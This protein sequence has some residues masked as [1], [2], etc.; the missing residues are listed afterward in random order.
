MRVA[1][2]LALNI[3]F[4]IEMLLRIVSM[5]GI[6]SY[7]HHPW[8]AFDCVMV[9]AGY[10][11]FIPMDGSAGSGLEGLKAL[12]ALRA[13]R[14]LRTIT[15]WSRLGE[16][17]QSVF[18]ARAKI[19]SGRDSEV[20]VA[21]GHT[22]PLPYLTLEGPHQLSHSLTGSLPHGVSGQLGCAAH[23]SQATLNA[24]T[25]MHCVLGS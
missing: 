23:T 1:A 17:F 24:P 20:V 16:K 21:P 13:M 9:L 12:R 8:N 25:C 15:R 7:L 5:G 22:L 10:T 14:P 4:T 19:G 2:D 6:L 3:A 18:G 11:M